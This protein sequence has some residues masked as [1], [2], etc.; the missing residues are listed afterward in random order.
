ML[1][2]NNSTIL[3]ARNNSKWAATADWY[4]SDTQELQIN[5]LWRLKFCLYQIQYFAWQTQQIEQ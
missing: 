1:L 3:K 5:E 2:E 4:S